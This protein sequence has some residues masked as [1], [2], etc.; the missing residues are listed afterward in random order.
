M[1][2]IQLTENH[3]KRLKEY[4]V[5]LSDSKRFNRTTFGFLYNVVRL[6]EIIL[7]DNEYDGDALV[8]ED[9]GLLKEEGQTYSDLLNWLEKLYTNMDDM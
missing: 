4:I 6:I 1:A 2:I 3:R 8:V 9:V 7:D 5:F